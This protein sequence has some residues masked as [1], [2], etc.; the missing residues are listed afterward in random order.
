M[1]NCKDK[2]WEQVNVQRSLAR[3]WYRIKYATMKP[4]R[5]GPLHNLPNFLEIS[6]VRTLEEYNQ[7]SCT[8]K[9]WSRNHLRIEYLIWEGTNNWEKK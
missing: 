5:E 1:P 3:N 7:T 2:G 9:S 4:S 6:S 8:P